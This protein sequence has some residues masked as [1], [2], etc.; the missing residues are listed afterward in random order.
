[1]PKEKGP[2]GKI[3]TVAQLATIDGNVPKVRSCNIRELMLPEGNEH[4]PIILAATDIRTPKVEQILANDVV[5]INW[6]FEPSGDQFRLTGRVT[7]V[8]EPGSR[9]FHPGGSVAFQRLSASGFDWEAKRVQTF[10]GLNPLLRAGRCCA[11]PGSLLDGG[12]EEMREWPVTIPTSTEATTEEEKK[13]VER[14][15]TNVTLVL[16]EPTYVDW[17]QLSVVPNQRTLF[18]REDDESWTETIVVP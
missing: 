3:P 4:L 18:R 16:V 14:A 11:P 10:D 1:M 9:I 2:N 5:Q 12:Y 8:P 6:W 7:L 15:L 17:L 13:L